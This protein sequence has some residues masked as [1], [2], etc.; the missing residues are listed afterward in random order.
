MF[1]KRSPSERAR[2]LLVRER[3]ATDDDALKARA[4]ER[5]GSALTGD[6]PSAVRLSPSE[7]R[8]PIVRPRRLLDRL[9]L[10][11]AALTIAGLA[12]AGISLFAG[13]L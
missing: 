7:F 5:A 9:P 12:V 10:I 8:A 13:R 4:L 2:E 3:E 1:D 6:R 11:A